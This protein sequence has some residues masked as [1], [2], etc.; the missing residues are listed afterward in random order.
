MSA[1]IAP[2]PAPAHEHGHGHERGH[3][4][5][6]G[7]PPAGGPV[8][9]DIGDDVG[10]LIVHV[11]P[12]RIGQELHVRRPG[13]T[14]TTHTGIWERRIGSRAVVVPVFPALVEGGYALLDRVGAPVLEVEVAGGQVTEL[15][16]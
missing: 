14:R 5:E 3:G 15:T 7:A 6:A 12:A 2:G 10:A 9:V 11:D 13:E 8:V 1:V 16:I 4:H